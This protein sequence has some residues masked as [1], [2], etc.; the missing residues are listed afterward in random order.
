[1]PL[2]GEYKMPEEFFRMWK[3]SEGLAAVHLETR[4]TRFHNHEPSE[5]EYTPL[6]SRRPTDAEKQ[7]I[8]RLDKGMTIPV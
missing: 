4:A 2:P 1:M 5:H 8:L 3:V 6:T 7:E